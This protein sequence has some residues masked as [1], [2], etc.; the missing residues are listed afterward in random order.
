M[1]KD[2]GGS[3]SKVVRRF[4]SYVFISMLIDFMKIRCEICIDS[5]RSHRLL[6]FEMSS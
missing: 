2:S 4:T 1:K 3:E 5:H 6:V